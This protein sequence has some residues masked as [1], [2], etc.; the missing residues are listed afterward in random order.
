MGLSDADLPG[1]VAFTG[2]RFVGAALLL[3]LLKALVHRKDLYQAPEGKE[4]P[5]LWIRCVL[6]LTC[7]LVS[8]FHGSNDAQKGMGLI[9][10]IL[11]GIVP[12]AFAL[13]SAVDPKLLQSVS[14]EMAQV[15]TIFTPL[16]KGET[17][18]KDDAETELTS[19]LK[20]GG[21][22]ATD[23]TWAAVGVMAQSVATDTTNITDFSKMTG[24]QR[25]SLRTDIYLV[26]ETIGKVLKAKTPVVRTRTSSRRLRRPRA[27]WRKSRSISRS[28]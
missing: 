25:Q 12:G 26:G 24:D 1:V 19:Y 13:N 6:V 7:T 16:G 27:M 22:P 21:T 3:L 11:V 17:I 20:Q 4:P 23:K 18:S 9:M 5:P 28:G 14:S 15:S 8:V 2:C 10:L